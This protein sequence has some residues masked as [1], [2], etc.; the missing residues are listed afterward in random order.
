M[1]GEVFLDTSAWFPIVHRG[2]PDHRRLA[3]TLRALRREGAPVITTNLVVAEMHVLLLRRVHRAAALAFVR[4][5]LDAPDLVVPST[6]A[7]EERA[8]ADW[9]ESYEDQEFSLT[10]AVSFALMAERGVRDAFALDHQ[11]AAAG[12]TLLPAAR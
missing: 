11:F 1:R 6:A 7:L 10:D 4:Q 12:F 9:L 8:V 5:A 2:H 3:R